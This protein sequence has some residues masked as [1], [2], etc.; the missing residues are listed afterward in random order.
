MIQ[1]DK[2]PAWL[3]VVL[4]LLLVAGCGRAPEAPPADNGL[5]GVPVSRELLGHLEASRAWTP[6]QGPAPFA[7]DVALHERLVGLIENPATRAAGGD[8]LYAH[9]R[10]EPTNLLWVE[11]AAI[12]NYLLR[13]TSDRNAMYALPALADTATAVGSCVHGRRF[14]GYGDRGEHYRRADRLRSRL[15]PMQ[16]L[17]LDRKLAWLVS[18][19]GDHVGAARRLLSRLP[20]ARRLGG[21]GLELHVWLDAS[22][23]LMRADRLDDALHAAARA[24]D[25]AAA[26]QGIMAGQARLAQADVLAARNETEAALDAYE[27]LAETSRADGSAWLEQISISR[28]AAVAGAADDAERT[29]A[30]D[31]RALELAILAQDSLNVPRCLM[32]IAYDHRLAGRLDSCLVH[33]E[34]A[35][36]WIAIFP[37]DRNSAVYPRLA[38]EYYFH[39]GD[40]AV[41]D[42]LLAEAARRGQGSGLAVDEAE[43]LLALVRQGLDGDQPDLAYRA[44]ARLDV[45]RPSLH[46]ALPD[47]NLL[48]DLEI[49]SADFLGRQ[50][51]TRR[52]AAALV[53]ADD[54]VTGGGGADKAWDLQRARGDLALR[55]GDPL[56][57]RRA[58]SACLDQALA[59]DRDDLATAARTRLAQLHLE[60]GRPDE[61]LALFAAAPGDTS[62]GVAFST[63]MTGHLYRGLALLDLGRTAEAAAE[64][65]AALDRCTPHTPA[66]LQAR[67]M[68]AEGRV[69][70]AQQRW[71]EADAALDR[72]R[73]VAESA[74]ADGGGADGAQHVGWDLRR[75]VAEAMVSLQ[76]DAPAPS[77]SAL[78]LLRLARR[79]MGETGAVP[80]VR[81]GVVVAYFVGERR[82]FL[83]VG[84]SG[85]WTLHPLPG[86]DELAALAAPVLAD[87]G[88]PRRT[89]EPGAL[90]RLAAAVLGEVDAAWTGKAPL[91]VAPDGPLAVVPWPALVLGDG[92]RVLDRG[93]VVTRSSFD[94]PTDA[95][96]G[97]PAGRLL[98]VGANTDLDARGDRLARL[99]EAEAEAA[100]VAEGWARGGADL[101]LGEGAGWPAI[102]PADLA[103]YDVIHV[104][105]HAVAHGGGAATLR[106]AGVLGDVPLTARAVRALPLRARLV[107]LSCCEAASGSRGAGGGLTDL[108][109]AF[110]QAGSGA[111]LAS[112]EV[113]DDAAAAALA[114]AFYRHWQQGAG[115]AEALRRAQL[116][117]ASEEGGRWR[118]PFFW[119]HYRLI[120]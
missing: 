87:T 9:W 56:G 29:L 26:G 50:G 83:W 4:P 25:L 28:A 91:V 101:R 78:E 61:A 7:R 104:A 71:A 63:V 1:V 75:A 40:Y 11:L 32:N 94:L 18:D 15:D 103:R 17:W 85:G 106:L 70:A 105:S 72:S 117:L 45:L 108:A 34:R 116:D 88:D 82:S 41:G 79:A 96:G 74:G 80:P 35:A 33:Q 46:D 48:A 14:Y 8:S 110:R 90:R 44:L 99:R 39:V 38:A 119:S 81:D 24:A 93:A 59:A 120:L 97:A 52:A 84:R 65:K 73:L 92:A 55:R 42:S 113:V 57:A 49:A 67:L 76:A 100:L 16:A 27:D 3:L 2:V 66:F 68:L 111:V 98:A 112:S 43:L 62:F 31:R 20:E 12:N 10:A 19:E 58:Y 6:P 23:I 51:E 5:V 36:R 118:H 102:D 77:R 13:R 89:P 86:Q 69:L 53:M 64:V 30:F 22:T 21:R 115:A 60:A 95:D 54:A 114:A 37:N 107:Y 47:G 109:H